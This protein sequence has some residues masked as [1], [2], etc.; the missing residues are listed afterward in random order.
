MSDGQ[1]KRFKSEKDVYLA[2]QPVTVGFLEATMPD[3]SGI[4]NFDIQPRT[5]NGLTVMEILG[6][7]ERTKAVTWKSS[8]ISAY[9]LPWK[10]EDTVSLDIAN[11]A[12][13]FFTSELNG[14]QFRIAPVGNQLRI[15]HVAGNYQGSATAQGS[16]DRNRYARQEFTQAQYRRSRALT[17]TTPIGQRSRF[18][19]TRGYDGP[20]AWTNVFGFRRTQFFG[21]STWHVWYQ[22]VQRDDNAGRYV[23]AAYRLGVF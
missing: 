6:F 15:V 9:W 8:R 18:P 22:T 13:Y 2:A 12:D 21:P 4:F 14:C 17:S 11:G 5:M 16:L 10:S 3:Q 23:A 1:N 19:G 7:D 20:H